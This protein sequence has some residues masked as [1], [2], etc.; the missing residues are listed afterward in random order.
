KS[1]GHIDIFANL[2][3]GVAKGARLGIVGPNG[4]GKTTLLRILA[5]AD[6]ASSGTVHKSRGVRIGYLSQEADFEMTGT[7]WDACESV[8]ADIIQKQG[9]LN[10]LEHEMANGDQTILE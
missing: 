9:E 3:F 8:F 6:E 10:R 5:G 1:Y 2:S 7:L 4:V